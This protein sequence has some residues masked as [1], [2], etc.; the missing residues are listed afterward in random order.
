[1]V[2]NP[3]EHLIDVD[4]ENISAD[5]KLKLLAQQSLYSSLSIKFVYA[6]AI[7]GTDVRNLL[8]SLFLTLLLSLLSFDNKTIILILLTTQAF[9]TIASK[10][11]S[12]VISKQLDELRISYIKFLKLKRKKNS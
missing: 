6:S 4:W 11:L 3:E 2:E 8:L 1:M 7:Y 10:S 5:D 9:F 12:I